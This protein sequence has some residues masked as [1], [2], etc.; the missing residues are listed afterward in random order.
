MKCTSIAAACLSV[1]ASVAPVTAAMADWSP[2]E[3]KMHYYDSS[4]GQWVGEAWFHCD[5]TIDV[6]GM[7]TGEATE[8]YIQACP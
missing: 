7:V 5:S 8:E 2:I 4:R 6:F 3:Y 1:I